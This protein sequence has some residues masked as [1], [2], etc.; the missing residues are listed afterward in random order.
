[1]QQAREHQQDRRTDADDFITRAQGNQ[2]RA[3]AH[4]VHRGHQCAFTPGL[5]GVEAHQPAT[6]RAHQEAHGEDRGGVQQLCGGVAFGE[7]GLGEVQG[8]GGV[9]VPVV[10]LDHV[11]NGTAEDRFDAAG[12]GSFFGRYGSRPKRQGVGVIH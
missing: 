1:M 8:E 11:A 5:V 3:E 12:S 9:D 2:Q 10:P 7:K 6:D 4:Q